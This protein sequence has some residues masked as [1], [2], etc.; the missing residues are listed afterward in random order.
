MQ[1]G[2]VHRRGT[3]LRRADGGV[4]HADDLAL[5][6]DQ[7]LAKWHRVGPTLLGLQVGKALVHPHAIHKAPH[8]L[9]GARQKEVDAFFGQ[10]DRA[11]QARSHRLRVEPF[12]QLGCVRQ[13]HEFVAGNIEYGC[14]GQMG[15]SKL[16]S[17]SAETGGW[18]SKALAAQRAGRGARSPARQASTARIM[19]WGSAA[20]SRSCSPAAKWPAPQGSRAYSPARAGGASPH[21]APMGRQEYRPCGSSARGGPI[22]C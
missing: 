18:L 21:H 3:P 12:A 16:Q 10:Q 14:H 9:G 7:H 22:G 6:L 5:D 17:G 4:V 20:L 8:C 1:R 13:G 15:V 19:P 11:L 2:W